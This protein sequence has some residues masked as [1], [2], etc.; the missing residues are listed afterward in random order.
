MQCGSFIVTGATAD[1]QEAWVARLIAKEPN[2]SEGQQIVAS[3]DVL[4]VKALDGEGSI[5]IETIRQAQHWLM[6]T[7]LNRSE[8]IMIIPKAQELTEEAQNAL[9]KTLEEPPTQAA[10]FLCIPHPELLLPT[11]ISRCQ[12]I[13]LSGPSQTD[14]STI[15]ITEIEEA[16]KQWSHGG[17]GEKWQLAAALGK[18]QVSASEFL[19]RLQIYLHGK[20]IE[21]QGGSKL[22]AQQLDSVFRASSYLKQNANARLVIENLFLFW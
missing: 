20:L 15:E 6:S 4:V 13:T 18:S 3:A 17:L 5:K 10:I 2:S 21:P 1:Q 19:D 22:L 12:E 16:L 9:L 14:L 11:V 7:P 8:K